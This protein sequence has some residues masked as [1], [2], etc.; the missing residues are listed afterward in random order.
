M[1]TVLGVTLAVAGAASAGYWEVVYDLE[2]SEMTT[3]AGLGVKSDPVTG[4][5]TLAF[6]TP[7]GA[8]IT[9]ARILAGETDTDVDQI[10]T[11]FFHLVGAPDPVTTLLPPTGGTPGTISGATFTPDIVA[12]SNSTGGNHCT[13]ALGGAG[14]QLAGF[15]IS[16]TKPITPTVPHPWTFVVPKLQF[17]GAFGES[18]WTSTTKTDTASAGAV[19]LTWIYKGKEIS[20]TYVFDP[21]PAMSNG[22]LT[23][24]AALL[25]LGGT[26]TLALR[27]KRRN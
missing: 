12:D 14:C 13:D 1:L 20:R 9:G 26:W 7:D 11:D 22:A 19:D 25:L 5:F 24:L 8:T 17:T 18:D 3:D 6:D 27:G 15:V 2:G 23:G 4:T 21:I 16:V 10:Y